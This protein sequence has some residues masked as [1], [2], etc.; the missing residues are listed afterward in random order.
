MAFDLVAARAELIS[1]VWLSFHFLVLSSTAICI[2]TEQTFNEASTA[3]EEFCDAFSTALHVYRG[4]TL[5]S[6]INEKI[7]ALPW[8]GYKDRLSFKDSEL[9][10]S[11][12]EIIM[13]HPLR[14]NASA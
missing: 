13:S 4:S 3:P 1:G 9:H 6:T 12:V 11:M 7:W 8:E 5:E 14:L 10:K 2:C